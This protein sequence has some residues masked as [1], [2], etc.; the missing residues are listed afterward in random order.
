[1][2]RYLKFLSGHH[3]G[4][5]FYCFFDNSIIIESALE[6]KMLMNFHI[7]IVLQGL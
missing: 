4:G 7:Y 5:G 2:D 1:M 6:L 3:T